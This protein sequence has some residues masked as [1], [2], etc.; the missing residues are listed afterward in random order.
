MSERERIEL[1]MKSYNLS[2]SQF[3][4]RTGIQRASVSHILS[5]RNRPSLEVMLKIY[6][7]FPGLSMEWLMAGIGEGPSVTAPAPKE[8][9][10]QPQPEGLFGGMDNDV[11]ENSNPI[12]FMN[13]VMVEPVAPVA[14]KSR[15][16]TETLRQADVVVP[17][18]EKR[19][20]VQSRQVIQQPVAQRKIKEVRIF[21]TDGTYETLVPEKN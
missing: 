6:E 8:S 7:A 14:K 10:V 2:S 4:D 12:P 5:G 15:I 20:T 17:Q 19:R 13:P 1:L 9:R 16:Q 21:Y 11:V 3:A 18:P